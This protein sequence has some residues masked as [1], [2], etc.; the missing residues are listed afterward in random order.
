MF[1]LLMYYYNEF[2]QLASNNQV[3]AGAVSLWGLSVVTWVARGVPTKIYTLLIEQTTTSFTITNAGNDGNLHRYNSVLAFINGKKGISLSRRLKLRTVAGWSISLANIKDEMQPGGG[4]HYFIYNGRL[5]WFTRDALPSSGTYQE[6][7]SMTIVTFGRKHQP[8]YD[9]ILEAIPEEKNTEIQ[10]YK[11][12]A[13]WEQTSVIHKRDLATVITAKGI[14]E[15]IIN[16]IEV[17]LESEEWYISRGISYKEATILTGPP[18]TGKTSLIKAIA[19][20]FNM[21][22][23]ELPLDMLSDISFRTAMST[24]PP[25][26]ICL[27]EDFD[28]NGSVKRRKNIQLHKPRLDKEDSESESKLGAYAAPVEDSSE[29]DF[30]YLTLSGILNTLDG[31]CD[32]H[33][34]LVFMT[35]NCIDSIDPAILRKGRTDNI[36]TLEWFTDKEIREYAKV[37]FPGIEL[38]DTVIFKDIP[39]CDAYA[40]FKE[41]RK[42]PE[43]FLAALPQARKYIAPEKVVLPR[44]H[45]IH[46]AGF[47]LD[48]LQS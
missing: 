47:V 20:F 25:R 27:I 8:F 41:H 23:Y 5:F 13:N 22:V 24:I 28:S 48:P 43:A 16:D 44:P 34:V 37:V 46:N 17:F 18:G 26:S 21:P 7:E 11:F 2:S 14:K 31:I 3:V 45:L 35:T 29:K 6:K 9:F 30:S 32:L 19:S 39:G 38:S 15:K 12:N 40:A 36:Y 33:G 1:D 4:R 10:L 42:D